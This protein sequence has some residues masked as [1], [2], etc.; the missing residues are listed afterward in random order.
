M[1]DPS[2]VL[3]DAIITALRANGALPSV[4]ANRV[5]DDVPTLP[6]FPYVNAGEVQVL[7]DDTEDCGDGSEVIARIHAWS[8]KPGFVET[9]QIAEAIR[10]TLRALDPALTGFTV[11]VVEFVQTQFLRDPDGQTRHAVVEFRYLIRH[12]S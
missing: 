3:Q 4:V 10:T 9:K 2:L 11:S 6:S 8:R 5:Y 12:T 7:G 1:S